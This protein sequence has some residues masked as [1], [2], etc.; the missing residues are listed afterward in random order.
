MKF[1]KN[2]PK[3]TCLL[4]FNFGRGMCYK[5]LPNSQKFAPSLRPGNH[6]IK[7]LLCHGCL[8]R[9]QLSEKGMTQLGSTNDHGPAPLQGEG[10]GPGGLGGSTTHPK[11]TADQPSKPLKFHSNPFTH[12]KVIYDFL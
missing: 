6:K 9:Q 2:Y 5:E 4:K 11:V 12:S 10:A 3:K 7:N 8:A 1:S